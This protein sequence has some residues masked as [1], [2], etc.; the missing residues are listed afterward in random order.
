MRFSSLSGTSG[1]VRRYGRWFVLAFIC[2]A[3]VLVLVPAVSLG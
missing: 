3:L 2:V 1:G